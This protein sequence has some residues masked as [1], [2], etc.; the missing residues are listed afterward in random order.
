[1]LRSEREKNRDQCNQ[2]EETFR[3]ADSLS[4]QSVNH[5]IEFV[6]F[7]CVSAAFRT[8]QRVSDEINEF[9][10]VFLLLGVLNSPLI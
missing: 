3:L 7:F 5:L 8:K 1:M 2:K 6:D 4:V 10:H 9:S